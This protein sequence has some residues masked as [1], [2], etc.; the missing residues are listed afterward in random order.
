MCGPFIGIPQVLEEKGVVTRFDADVVM[1][2]RFA[3]VVKVR[4]V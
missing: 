4:C 1:H 2:I 3:Q